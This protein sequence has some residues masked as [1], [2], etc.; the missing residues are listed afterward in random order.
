MELLGAKQF[1]VTKGLYEEKNMEAHLQ[2]QQQ[3]RKKI[4]L[5]NDNNEGKK[6]D[7]EGENSVTNL[8]KVKQDEESEAQTQDTPLRNEIARLNKQVADQDK[9]IDDLVDEREELEDEILKLRLALADAW[10]LKLTTDAEKVGEVYRRTREK[11]KTAKEK[12]PYSATVKSSVNQISADTNVKNETKLSTCNSTESTDSG[13]GLHSLTQLIDDRVN[14]MIDVKLKEGE[15]TSSGIKLVSSEDRI[16]SLSPECTRLVKEREQNVIV[17]GLE[18]GEISDTQLIKDIFEATDTQQEPSFINRLGP[19]RDGKTRP[20]MVRMRNKEEKEQFMSKLWMLKN[21]RRRFKRMSITND[22]TLEERYMIK[23]YVEE[24]K[25]RNTTERN[26]YQWKVRG[27]PKE[28]LKLV[29][30]MR[31]A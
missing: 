3:E 14:L 5:K 21:A 17:H 12:M 13:L 15:R 4:Q 6:H 26:E 20:L 2:K 19:K 28:G 29:R 18:E 30:I 24:A 23:K 25:I 1:D 11:T 27:T 7:T 31:Q 16:A 9:I 8:T 10:D 22:Y